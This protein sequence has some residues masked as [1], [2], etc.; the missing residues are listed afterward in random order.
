[1]VFNRMI[2]RTFNNLS[3]FQQHQTNIYFV[4][5]ARSHVQRRFKNG[6]TTVQQQCNDRPTTVQRPSNKGQITMQQQ[7]NQKQ[8]LNVYSLG[9]FFMDDSHF[10]SSAS[11]E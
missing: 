2:W 8:N 5:Y 6:P 9:S 3:W 7:N 1:M 11:C 4:Q 10:M